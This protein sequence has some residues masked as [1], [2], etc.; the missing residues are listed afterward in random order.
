[1]ASQPVEGKDLL[2]AAG[3]DYKRYIKLVSERSSAQKVAK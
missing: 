1:M 3:V 2:L